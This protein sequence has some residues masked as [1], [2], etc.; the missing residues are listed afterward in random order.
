M[1]ASKSDL[2]RLGARARE[3][4]PAPEVIARLAEL[5]RER[6]GGQ[7]GRVEE[8]RRRAE[9]ELRRQDESDHRDA[10]H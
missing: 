3:P 4:G 6:E 8:F 1:N 7:E 5:M 10:Q 2:E 9:A